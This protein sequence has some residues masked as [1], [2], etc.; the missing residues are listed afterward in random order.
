MEELFANIVKNDKMSNEIAL[1]C[2]NLIIEQDVE[3]QKDILGII[4]KNNE[5]I[6]VYNC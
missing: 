6:V 2:F 1:K 5:L 4:E 3:R